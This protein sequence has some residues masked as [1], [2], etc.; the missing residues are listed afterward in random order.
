MFGLDHAVA[1][2]FRVKAEGGGG[3]YIFR[4][5]TRLYRC[6]RV[7]SNLVKNISTK[8]L[9][10]LNSLKQTCRQPYDPSGQRR[11]SA[12]DLSTNLGNLDFRTGCQ[13]E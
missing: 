6:A 10:C 2:Y 12:E 11:R 5:P 8:C 13:P 1:A 3:F 9:S 4:Q 7:V